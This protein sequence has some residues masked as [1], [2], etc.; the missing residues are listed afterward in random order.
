MPGIAAVVIGGTAITGGIGG[1]PRTIVGALIIS[2]NRVG[3][4]I[5]GVIRT[6]GR[7]SMACW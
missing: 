5:L 7:S 1:L 3:L 4:G 6:T 2:V